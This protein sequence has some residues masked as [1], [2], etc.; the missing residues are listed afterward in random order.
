MKTSKIFKLFMVAAAAI[1]LASCDKFEDPYTTKGKT[2]LADPSNITVN[3]DYKQATITW[4]A[5][6]GADQYY[7]EL[8]NASNFVSKKGF[9]KTN[10]YYAPGL[11]QL[12]DYTFYVKAIPSADDAPS[13]AGSSLVSVPFKTAD[14]SAYLWEAKAKVM[15]GGVD[16]GRT[17]IV[18][19]EFATGQY[20]IKGWFGYEGYNM[21]I[22]LY[23]EGDNTTWCWETTDSA[24]K[25]YGN[26]DSE[27]NCFYWA[28]YPANAY[29]F[30]D[31]HSTGAGYT[32]FYSPYTEFYG[33]SKESGKL[34]CWGWIN[35]T[36]WTSWSVEW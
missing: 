35:N 19:Y 11:N 15:V 36:T 9:V 12:T 22:K 16:T 30:Y 6:S 33:C 34:L 23:G 24:D 27:T 26:P 1:S 18:M 25:P 4:D 32:W 29:C 20:T 28:D 21:V 14:A 2:P 5:V 10:S 13:V 17:A 3:A 31:G 7:Y 8:R